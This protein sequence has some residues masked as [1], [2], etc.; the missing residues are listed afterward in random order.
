MMLFHHIFLE[1]I[2]LLIF[3]FFYSFVRESFTKAFSK[4]RI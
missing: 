3:C 4:N 1:F 2:Y